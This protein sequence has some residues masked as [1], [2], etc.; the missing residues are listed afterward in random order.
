MK[1]IDKFNIGLII[2]CTIIYI[3]LCYHT[4]Y[5]NIVS[6]VNFEKQHNPS[7]VYEYRML[8]ITSVYG[9]IYGAILISFQQRY[10]TRSVTSIWIWIAIL[11]ISIM[12]VFSAFYSQI[13]SNENPNKFLSKFSYAIVPILPSLVILSETSISEVLEHGFRDQR[14]NGYKDQQEYRPTEKVGGDSDI[15]STEEYWYLSDK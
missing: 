2:L 3:I 4:K 14:D 1:T 10:L 15:Y 11:F 13:Y 9:F 12:L 7:I 6:D 5:K 8:Y